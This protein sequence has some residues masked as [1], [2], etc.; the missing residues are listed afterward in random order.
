MPMRGAL[1]LGAT[2]QGLVE[3]LIVH[4]AERKVYHISFFV[5]PA[6]C[7]VLR[8]K[9]VFCCRQHGGNQ[10][11]G[12]SSSTASVTLGGTLLAL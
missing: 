12:A 1:T 10:D 11:S 7:A 4:L 3:A 8:Y 9:F 2:A 6:Q 5:V